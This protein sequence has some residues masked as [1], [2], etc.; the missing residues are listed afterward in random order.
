MLVLGDEPQPVRAVKRLSGL[1]AA[2]PGII[3]S[4]PRRVIGATADGVLEVE[5]GKQPF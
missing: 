2:A 1:S 5:L 3:S 4:T